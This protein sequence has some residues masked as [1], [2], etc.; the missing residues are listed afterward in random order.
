MSSS[1]SGMVSASR[2]LGL[3]DAEEQVGHRA[4]GGLAGQPALEDRAGV[5]LPARGEHR[6]AVGEHDDDARIDRGDGPEQRELL[7]RQ[8]DV[9]A[10]EALG[11]VGRRAA[12]GR[13]RPRRRR[14]QRD[15]LLD[16]RRVVGVGPSSA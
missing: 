11:L 2:P 13:P 16:E 1:R 3:A 10:V 15:G 7:R 14:G 4:A 5:V 12:R 8:V 6:R 9:R